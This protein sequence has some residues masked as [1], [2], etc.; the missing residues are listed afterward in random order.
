VGERGLGEVRSGFA[1][2]D[3]FTAG[4]NN[5]SRVGGA[6]VAA[7][8][9]A[10]ITTIPIKAP[11]DA[12]VV[13]VFASALNPSGTT[14]YVAA[15][16][17]SSQGGACGNFSSGVAVIDMVS[18]AQV[19]TIP[20][21][22]L[23]WGVTVNSAGTRIYLAN[24][25]SASDGGSSITVIDTHKNAVTATIPVKTPGFVPL[26]PVAV[27]SSPS[28]ARLYVATAGDPGCVVVFDTNDNTVVATIP[29]FYVGAYDLNVLAVKPD[30]SRVYVVNTL[31]PNGFVSVLDTSTH[32]VIANIDVGMFPQEIAVNTAGTR[33]YVT[34]FNSKTVS[35][36]DTSSNSVTETIPVPSGPTS[37]AINPAGTRAY[38]AVASRLVGRG[39]TPPAVA[40]I[41]LTRNVVI[42]SVPIGTGPDDVLSSITVDRVGTHAYVTQANSRGPI[43]SSI[44]VQGLAQNP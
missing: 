7:A 8:E 21:K 5:R 24:A 35:V 41:D 31:S 36:I 28:N 19:A 22:G 1:A 10:V 13:A 17:Q 30:G 32:G 44:V 37:I 43:G 4:R 6:T 15:E 29:G 39:Y 3:G 9:A 12:H 42:D 16:Y 33:V 25:A 34:N 18:K 14:E 11:P 27:A 38:V 40:V 23:A 20:V 2:T 26:G